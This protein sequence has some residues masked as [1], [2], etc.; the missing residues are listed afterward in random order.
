MSGKARRSHGDKIPQEDGSLPGR[1][2]SDAHGLAATTENEVNATTR[3]IGFIGLG[4]MGSNMAAQLAAHGYPL[5]L[6][7][8]D[9]ATAARVAAG[10][11]EAVALPSPR[12]VAAVADVVITMLPNG[13]VVQQVVFGDDGLGEAL[14]S[15]SLLIDCS[16]AEPWLTRDT[17][18]RLGTRGIAMIDAPVSGAEVGARTGTLVFLC[19]G[20][21]EHVARARPMLDVMGRRVFHLGPLGSGHI[22]KTINNCITAMT[23]LA[24]TEGLLLGKRCGLE[25][26]A[27]VDVIDEATAASWISRTQFRQ[28]IFNRQFDDPFKLALMAKD[29]GIALQ[30]AANADLPLALSAHGRDLW[31]QAARQSDPAASVSDLVRWLEE[32]TGITLQSD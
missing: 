16:S 26:E 13:L 21:P 15:G 29:V 18:H 12:A 27:M 6:H 24:T 11:S 19:G 7:D 25:P 31:Q 2:A 28:R 17:A 32:S 4:V 8:R 20:D 3:R 9:A 23:F 5:A 14:A 1:H 10:L 22:M 30:L